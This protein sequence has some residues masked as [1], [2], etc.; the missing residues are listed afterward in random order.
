MLCPLKR[1]AAPPSNCRQSGIGCHLCREDVERIAGHPAPRLR[2]MNICEHP[3]NSVAIGWS[4]RKRVDV[5][6]VVSSFEGHFPA[7]LFNW[8]KTREI[9]PDTFGIR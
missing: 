3:Q 6:K 8:T 2:W 1:T 7:L 5:H 4:G 9:Q